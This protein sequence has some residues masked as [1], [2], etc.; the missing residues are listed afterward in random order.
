MDISLTIAN[1]WL[2]LVLKRKHADPS[3]GSSNRLS[4]FIHLLVGMAT[5]ITQ[6]AKTF[7]KRNFLNTILYHNLTKI[8]CLGIFRKMAAGWSVNILPWIALKISFNIF[9]RGDSIKTGMLLLCFHWSNPSKNNLQKSGLFWDNLQPWPVLIWA[10][11]YPCDPL[12]SGVSWDN[13][14]LKRL[15]GVWQERK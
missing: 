7:D 1:E 8:G 15:S 10:S 2:L 3:S 6:C 4:N 12:I 13:F 11:Y 9:I 14:H 5:N